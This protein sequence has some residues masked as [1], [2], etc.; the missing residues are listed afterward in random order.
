MQIILRCK[1]CQHMTVSDKDEDV[2]LEIDAFDEELRFVCR[3]CKKENKLKLTNNK[4]SE[5][6][7]RISLSKY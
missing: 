6:L 7:P 3:A 5:P 1:F 4:K 2:C